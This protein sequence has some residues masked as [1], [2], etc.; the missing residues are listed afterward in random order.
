MDAK[1][2][3]KTRMR[4]EEKPGRTFWILMVVG[5]VVVGTMSISHYLRIE[6]VRGDSRRGVRL[7]S[8]PILGEVPEF[9]LTERN[10][11]PI[12]LDALRGS[13]WVA[14][15]IFT[16]CA[17]PCPIMSQRMKELQDALEGERLGEVRCVSFTLDPVRDTPEIL[18]VYADDYRADAD[19]WLFL[20]GDKQQVF[21]LT[22]KGF[23]LAVQDETEADPIIHST[24]FVLVD[25]EGRIRGYYEAITDDEMQDLIGVS[26]KPLPADVKQ[27]MLADIRSLVREGGR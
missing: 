24:R 15:F 19:R 4:P 22:L 12:G 7:S 9:S 1:T 8:L 3:D 5:V 27:Q 18:K 26:G 6:R 25:R 2:E 23:K 10:G 17:G 16:Y 20:T 11:S 21:D 13:V 14:D